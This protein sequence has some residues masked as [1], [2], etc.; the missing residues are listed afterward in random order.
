MSHRLNTSAHFHSVSSSVQTH[1]Y[2]CRANTH[3]S[4]TRVCSL[5]LSHKGVR[6]A[7]PSVFR[8]LVLTP[9]LKVCCK[10]SGAYLILE[11]KGGHSWQSHKNVTFYCIYFE[12]YRKNHCA[13]CIMNDE[14][15][16][17]M[18]SGFRKPVEKAQC[19]Y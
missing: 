13:W 9:L 5:I 3:R 1:F 17:I 7:S 19:L 2:T 4:G 11:L 16:N 18:V 12:T 6:E 8:T 15:F 10:Y 14:F